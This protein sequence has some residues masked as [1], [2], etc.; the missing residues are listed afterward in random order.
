MDFRVSRNS[1]K[2]YPYIYIHDHPSIFLG[3]RVYVIFGQEIKN[4]PQESQS[5]YNIRAICPQES[6]NSYTARDPKGFIN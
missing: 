4:N 5:K 2:L 6:L 3:K 1:L